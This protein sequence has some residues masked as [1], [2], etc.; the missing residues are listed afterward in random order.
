MT[1]RKKKKFSLDEWILRNRMTAHELSQKM[2]CSLQSIINWRRGYYKPMRLH[3]EL[4]K[5]LTN[6]EVEV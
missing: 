4:L 1:V 3:L 6:Y 2:G 5:E